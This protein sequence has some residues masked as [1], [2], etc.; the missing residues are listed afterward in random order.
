MPKAKIAA[1]QAIALDDQLAEAHNSLGSYKLFFEW[2]TAGA[3]LEY[4]K[5][6]ALDPG[7]ANAHHF[8]SHCLQFSGRG[9]EALREMKQAVEVEPLSAVNN[10]ELAWAYYLDRQYDASIDQSQK[11][12][13]MEP[14][15]GYAYWVMGLAYNAKGMFPE[16]LTALEKGKTL[17][18]DWL[19]LQA[20]LAYTHA[21]GGSPEQ[22]RAML[23][24]IL[25][26]SAGGYVNEVAIASVYVALGENDKAMS[27]LEQGYIG[28]C[29]W[30]KWVS[31]KPKLDKLR[32]DPRFK[33][34]VDRIRS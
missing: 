8:Y 15:F 16:A 30:M 7:Y 23:A 32:G 14:G 6:I 3:E 13:E 22:G 25:K 27:W 19:E 10:A 26:T 17:S 29:S 21:S 18:P 20:E 31:I 2:D 11:T 34:L 33:D 4:R 1:L 9:A 24:T 5:A 28:R 12:L